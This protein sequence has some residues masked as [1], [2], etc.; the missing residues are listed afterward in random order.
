MNWFDLNLRS[1]PPLCAFDVG[2]VVWLIC[3]LWAGPPANAPQRKANNNPNQ[4]NKAKE[5]KES[6]LFFFFLERQFNETCWIEWSGKEEKTMNGAP[7]GSAV[8][9]WSNQQ[10]KLLHSS[11]QKEVLMRWMKK[12]CWLGGVNFI[13]FFNHQSKINKTIQSKKFD[14]LLLIV[15][16]DWLIPLHSIL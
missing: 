12:V 5:K 1:Q 9:E 15:W 7:S 6:E 4:L 3:G 11:T 16:I 10:H 13:P 14:W 8:S 2:W